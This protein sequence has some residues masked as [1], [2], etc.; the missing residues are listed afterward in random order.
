MKLQLFFKPQINYLEKNW[1]FAKKVKL[2]LRL[3]Y[4]KRQKAPSGLKPLNSEFF[5]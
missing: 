5:S 4:K 3:M 1:F 2:W